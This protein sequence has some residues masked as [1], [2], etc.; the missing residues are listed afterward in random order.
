VLYERLLVP[1]QE[2]QY[3]IP[4][5]EYSF[6]DPATGEYHTLTSEPIPIDIAPGAGL[7][8][9]NVAPLVN[10]GQE[11]VEQIGTDIRHLKPVPSQLRFGKQAVTDSPL[12]WL[13]W[14]VPLVGLVGHFVWKR[15]AQYWAN[16]GQLVRS[17]QARK[18][19]KQA[20]TRAR[21][22][23]QNAYDVPG[24]IL[25]NYLANKLD[26][27]VAGLT[28]QALATRLADRE[29]PAELIDRV[30]HC[31]ASCE[32]GRYGP[33]ADDPAHAEN[34]LIEVDGVTQDLEKVL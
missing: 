4:A 8:V 3:T 19:A 26:L 12:Y 6:F 24:Q 22:E 34:L 20:L 31:L 13:A 27:P 15:R 9:Q 28:H 18:K 2:G 16:N 29:V 25:A 11:I 33:G 10:G 5:L 14:S 30:Q 32:L 1:Q 21:K 17:S 7:V 23:D